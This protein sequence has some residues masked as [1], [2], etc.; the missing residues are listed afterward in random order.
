MELIVAGIRVTRRSP[1][2]TASSSAPCAMRERLSPSSVLGQERNSA[3]LRRT[4]KAPAFSQKAWCSVRVFWTVGGSAGNDQVV[5]TIGGTGRHGFGLFVVLLRLLRSP[6]RVAVLGRFGVRDLISA[7]DRVAVFEHRG[8]QCGIAFCAGYDA[9]CG[10]HPDQSARPGKG[11]P[12]RG[13][14]QL[15]ADE[16]RMVGR[17]DGAELPSPSHHL[18]HHGVLHLGA[19]NRSGLSRDLGTPCRRPVQALVDPGDVCRAGPGV[20]RAPGCRCALTA[21]WNRRPSFRLDLG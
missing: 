14:H 11:P 5:A 1:C 9:F 21:M 16:G 2:R 8:N 6:F 19:G 15:W 12:R 17:G 13:P 4:W 18:H 3:A 7:F 10:R 20:V